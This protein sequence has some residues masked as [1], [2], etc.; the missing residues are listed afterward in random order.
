MPKPNILLIV[1]DTLR[2]DRLSG[3]GHTRETSPELDAFAARATVFDRAVSPA[4]W[5]IPAHASLFTGV[6]PSTHQLTEAHGRLSGMF[7]TLAEILHGAGYHTT[8]FCNNALLGALDNGL[9]RGF[10]HF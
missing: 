8:G 1:L 3:Y 5:T 6:Y 10:E 2:R 9:R 7:P 4:Q